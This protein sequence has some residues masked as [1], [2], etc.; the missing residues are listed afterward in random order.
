MQRCRGDVATI[1]GFMNSLSE[2]V[3][4]VEKQTNSKGGKTVLFYGMM[5]QKCYRCDHMNSSQAE[6]LL[7]QKEMLQLAGGYW[8]V[9]M[10][11]VS[12]RL[13]ITHS[14]EL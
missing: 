3:Q 6:F 9:I 13:K 4:R 12:R 14:V 5:R 11:T 2:P 7:E 8:P 10:A 1:L